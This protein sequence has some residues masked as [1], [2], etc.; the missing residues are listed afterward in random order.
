M[1][2]I[3][4]VGM[5]VHKAITVICMIASTGKEVHR[6]VVE[7]KASALVDT[8]ESIR[9]EVHLTFEESIHSHWLYDL[10]S[11]FVAKHASKESTR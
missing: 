4:Y 6:F 5:D 7:T 3:Y 9:S 2:D 11:P 10:L 1:S 8:I